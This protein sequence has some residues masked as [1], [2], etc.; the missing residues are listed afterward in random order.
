[1]RAFS[2]RW[3]V[4]LAWLGLLTLVGCNPA[5]MLF[6][7]LPIE[8]KEPAKFSLAQEGA[9]K[10]KDRHHQ[11]KVLVHTTL[12]PGVDMEFLN[13]DRQLNS[14]VSRKLDELCKA[15][16]E[17]V[18]LIAPS[19]LE[20]FKRNHPNWANLD[21]AEIGKALE[22]DYVISLEVAK[23]TIYYPNARGRLLR[24]QCAISIDVIDVDAEPGDL[25]AYTEEYTTVYPNE[26]PTDIDATTN[27]ASF[28]KG[29][30]D[31][32][33]TDIAFRFSAYPTDQHIRVEQP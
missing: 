8:P 11:T 25:P 32:V 28:R 22:A 29:F 20:Q 31:R 16:K 9:K 17:K 18:V 5:T 7:F 6:F 4:V 33:S 27:P 10:A 23:M 24:G 1:M 30:L 12:G 14:S 26:N 19:K 21:P 13:V 3:L 15:N 2:R